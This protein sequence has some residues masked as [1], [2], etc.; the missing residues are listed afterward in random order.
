MQ[1]KLRARTDLK[2]VVLGALALGLVLTPTA[3]GATVDG[4]DGKGPGS[5]RETGPVAPRGEKADPG[6]PGFSAAERGKVLVAAA[7]AYQRAYPRLTREGAEAAARGQDARKQLWEDVLA[8]NTDAFGGAWFDPRA[9]VLHVNVTDEGLAER[10]LARADEQG[11]KVRPHLVKVSFDELDALAA[12]LRE[13]RDG[14]G[15]LAAGRVG[16][17]VRDNQVVV[18]VP[19]EELERARGEAPRHVR[20]EVAEKRDVEADACLDRDDCPD[21][22][23]AGS[24]L[25]K[26]SIGNDWCSAGATAKSSTTGRRYVLTAGH[27]VG[28]MGEYWGTANRYIGTR[29]ASQN[30]GDVDVATIWVR[31]WPFRIQNNGEVWAQWM[32]NRAVDMDAVAPTQSWIWV[33]DVVCLAANYTDPDAF[34]NR[35]GVIGANADAGVRGMTRVDGVDACGG[36]SGGG[37]YWLTSSGSRWGY[38]VHSRSSTGCNGSNGG[39]QSWFTTLPRVKTWIPSLN[40]ETQ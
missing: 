25:W 38:G 24:I 31:Y 11:L 16:L 23:R 17:D 4:P 2:A 5:H 6:K 10:V 30:A 34:G 14:L 15:E 8:E 20:V 9:N 12:E 35:C 13:S 33:G 19:K 37:W 39:D 21:A 26:G 29:W 32:A 22:V 18:H 27:C 40:Y 1:R 3:A 28:A 36:D 7:D